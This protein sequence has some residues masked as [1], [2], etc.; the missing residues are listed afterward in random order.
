MTNLA[1]HPFLDERVPLLAAARVNLVV[2]PRHLAEAMLLVVVVLVHRERLD[3]V[4]LQQ[5]LEQAVVV[6]Q[7]AEAE[8][9]GVAG[10]HSRD[11][12]L[13]EV[14][15]RAEVEL[16]R[17]VEQRRHDLRIVGAELQAV[18]ALLR[19]KADPLARRLRRL[20]L[21]PI[22]ALAAER[23]VIREDPRRDDLVLRRQLALVQVPVHR[24]ARHAADGRDAVRHPQL[25]DVF[26]IARLAAAAVH[27]RV[28][29]ARHQVHAGAVDLPGALRRAA[30]FVDRH[31]REA[32]ADD[33]GDAVVLHDDVH[34][35]ARRRAGAVDHG[36]AADDQAIE[37]PLAVA[38]LAGRR[39]IHLLCGK[40]DGGRHANDRAQ[41]QQ[42]QVTRHARLQGRK[43]T[44]VTDGS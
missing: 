34:R 23:A 42:A 9:R 5:R 16:L 14:R 41:D 8:A 33:V 32:D 40:G 31:A 24:S 27:V 39:R 25:V 11:A 18:D 19:G 6:G 30:A 7:R 17:L 12:H 35:P 2:Q 4:I 28:D 21:R 38:G 3:G 36:D 1:I 43:Y 44:N 22:P 29:E 15:R 10:V 37:R 26:G 20:R 13:I